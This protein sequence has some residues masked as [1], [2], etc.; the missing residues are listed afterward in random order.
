MKL[1]ER[2]ERLRSVFTGRHPADDERTRK[3]HEIERLAQSSGAS[4]ARADRALHARQRLHAELDSA[5][6]SFGRRP[7]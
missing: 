1:L 5:V 4:L 3:G 6:A 7:R 2:L